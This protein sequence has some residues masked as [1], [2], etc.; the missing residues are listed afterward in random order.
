MSMLKTKQTNLRTKWLPLQR[1]QG[2]YI[3][4]DEVICPTFQLTIY[5]AFP[6]DHCTI[7]KHLIIEPFT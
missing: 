7:S 5:L 3:G 2:K 6:L 1:V 4:K